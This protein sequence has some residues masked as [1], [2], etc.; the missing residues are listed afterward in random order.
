MHK[1]FEHHFIRGRKLYVSSENDLLIEF[2]DGLIA[3]YA[4]LN[5]KT[6][7]IMEEKNNFHRIDTPAYFSPNFRTFLAFEDQY[8]LNINKL[9]V[10]QII[11]N[12]KPQLANNY[13]LPNLDSVSRMHERKPII[14]LL[15]E[16]TVSYLDKHNI[17]IRCSLDKN[18]QV[19]H[20]EMQESYLTSD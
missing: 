20:N 1:E 13:Q 11:G 7:R 4:I 10:W 6:A 2:W 14:T 18:V 19:H 5:G 15:G 9:I 8:M 12:E 17:L 3:V 16:N